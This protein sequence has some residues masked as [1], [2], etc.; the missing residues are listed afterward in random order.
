MSNDRISRNHRISIISNQLEGLE[1]VYEELD[2]L[3]SIMHPTEQQRHSI[4]VLLSKASLL[5]Q[6]VTPHEIAQAQLAKMK[7]ELNMR[8][9]DNIDDLRIQNPVAVAEW[10]SILKGGDFRDRGEYRDVD[11]GGNAAGQQSISFT[12]GSA[13]GYLVKQEYDRR[14]FQS[15]AQYDEI[16]D[17]G[18]CNPIQTLTGAPMTTPAVDD[19]SGSPATMQQAY[20]V[21]ENTLINEESVV[22]SKV[23]W[24][25]TPKFASGIIRTSR[26]LFK[27]AFEPVAAIL[28]QVFAQ[29]FALALGFYAV[30]GNGNGQPQGLIPSLPASTV[31]TS[32]T[33][34]LALTDFE[35]VYAE[36]PQIYR[37]AAKWYMNDNVR[38]VVTKLLETAGR[39]MIGPAESLLGKPIVICNSMP[40][41]GAGTASVAVLAHP[42]YLLQ[43]R[44]AGS[45]IACY[46][47]RYMD[48]G[49]F[50]FQSF[51]RFDSQPMLFGSVFPPVASLNQHS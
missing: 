29:R 39:P 2:V 49:E 19:T 22:A 15:L 46:K 50:G 45:Y 20:I 3:R 44:V 27:D 37:K 21:G 18:N 9:D 13:G 36:L 43:R 40:T 12:D 6:G 10:M 41:A 25:S 51:V 17:A 34:T 5:R 48:Y 38:N 42:G 4:Q 24:Q 28:E 26:E 33:S 8:E 16:L 23:S 14:L 32:A 35:A 7:R 47:E 1:Q 30:Q 31:V 11:S